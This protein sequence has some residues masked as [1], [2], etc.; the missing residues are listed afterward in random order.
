MSGM[1]GQSSTKPKEVPVEYVEDF[2]AT[3]DGRAGLART[4]RYRLRALMSDLGGQGNLTYQQRSLCKRAIH[5]ERLL[6]QKELALMQDEK[7]DVNAYLNGVNV[8]SGLF[9]RLGLERRAALVPDLQ[10]YL[11]A[12]E[13]QS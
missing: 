11:R 8:L 10:R 9:S 13:S 2:L 7:M 6:E 12:R 5:L 3:M 4:L 1:K